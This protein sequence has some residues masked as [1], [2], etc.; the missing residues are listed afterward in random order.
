MTAL[1]AQPAAEIAKILRLRDALHEWDHVESELVYEGT[2]AVVPLVPLVSV[3]IPTFKRPLLLGE[4]VGSVLSQDCDQP[5]ELVIV[6]NDPD[7]RAHEALIAR[8]PELRSRPFRYYRN[9]TNI[10]MFGNFNR[11]LLLARGEWT[12]LLNDDDLLDANFLSVML[13]ALAA[14]P[15]IDGMSCQK[16]VL[17]QSKVITPPSPLSPR[18]FAKR[19]LVESLFMGGRDRRITPRKLFWGLMIG[20]SVGFVFRTRVGRGLGGFYPEEKGSADF[21]FTTRFAALYDLRQYRETLASLRVAE[22]ETGRPEEVKGQ[23][24]SANA[25]REVLI[26]TF[27]PRSWKRLMPTLIARDRAAYREHW[28]V[29]LPADEL[30]KLLGRPIGADRRYLLWFVKLLLRGY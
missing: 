21:W 6:D 20:N 28:N 16:R 9:P 23:M 5:F 15:D 26:G 1:T 2:G 24:V 19:M 8:Y 27:V 25:L 11:C 7:S 10:G 18:R 29:D 12:T 17:Y 30:S 4:A 13:A 14:D 3:V 22:N